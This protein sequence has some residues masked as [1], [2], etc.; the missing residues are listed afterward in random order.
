MKIPAAAGL[1][2]A[3]V[4]SCA[5]GSWPQWTEE[6]ISSLDCGMTVSEVRF[7]ARQ[8]LE[9]V[10]SVA[11]RGVYGT[12]TIDKG[13]VSVWLHFDEG[14]LQAVSRWRPQ[15]RKLKST[16]ISPKRNLCTGELSFFVRLFRP[17]ALAAPTVYLDDQKVDGF[18]WAR[19][20]EVS[21]GGHEL[22]VEE[23]GY[24]PIVKQVHFDEGDPGELWL[25][26]TI[27]DLH[28]VS[29]ETSAPSRSP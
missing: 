25:E 13:H 7:L 15:A 17:A 20:Y 27:D 10:T 12:H 14:H 28:P 8:D 24:E 5:S 21:A 29:A 1:L 19:P 3:G 22:R 6:L 26:I 18:P 23:E 16:Y 4:L 11:F 9:P 2:A